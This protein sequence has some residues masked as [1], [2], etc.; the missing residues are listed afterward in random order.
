MVTGGRFRSRGNVP[1]SACDFR[2]AAIDL[3]VAG[4]NALGVQTR[5]DARAHGAPNSSQ[6]AIDF[7]LASGG[8]FI[9]PGQFGD[10]YP[11]IFGGRDKFDRIH[12]VMWNVHISALTAEW[13]L[14]V[15]DEASAHRVI[16]AFANGVTRAI[17]SDESH[18]IGV[19]RQASSRLK[20]K[21][22]KFEI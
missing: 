10:G 9:S 16:D 21:V 8:D 5:L 2:S 1:K 4:Q 19:F 11:Q 6:P 20:L 13:P 12:V 7:G 14:L 3:E 15:F 22:V 18:G 17:L